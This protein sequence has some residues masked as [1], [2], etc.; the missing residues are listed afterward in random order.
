MNDKTNDG[1][2][3]SS[4]ALRAI[5]IWLCGAGAIGGLGCATMLVSE[6]NQNRGNPAADAHYNKPV[7]T[8]SVFALA[9]PDDALAEKIG[10]EDAIAFLGRQHTYLLI[11]GGKQLRG[12]A[13][14]LDGNKLILEGTPRQ[15]F[16]KGKVIWGSVSLRYV[17]GQDAAQ[18]ASDKSKFQTLGFALDKQGV[19]RLSVAVKGAIYPA[20]KFTSKLSKDLPDAFKKSRDIVFYNPPDSSPPPDLGKLAILIELPLAVVVDVALIPVYVVGFVV[21]VMSFN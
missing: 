1:L 9:Q 18:E 4:P 17:P 8:D 13:R 12:I 11:E 14:E 19:Y 15:L 6:M 21:L 2:K 3:T 7:L 10:H 16:L 5:A 20:A